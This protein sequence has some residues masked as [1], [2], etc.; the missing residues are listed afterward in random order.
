LE[1]GYESPRRNNAVAGPRRRASIGHYTAL[2][3]KQPGH[4]QTGFVNC[5]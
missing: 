3:V 4:M 2:R 1:M 5:L